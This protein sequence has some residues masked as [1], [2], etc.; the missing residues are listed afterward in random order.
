VV[1]NLEYGKAKVKA[2]AQ[3][4]GPE[5]NIAASTNFRVGSFSQKDIAATSDVAFTGGTSQ[6]VRA[7]SKEDMTKLRSALM[8][9][10]SVKAKDDLQ[11]KLGSDKFLI[12]KSLTTQI[13][14]EEYD[15][16]SDEPADSLKLNLG[17][18]AKAMVVNNSDFDQALEN[19]LLPLIPEGFELT[20]DIKKSIT[21]KKADSTGATI[22]IDVQA[23]LL[24]KLDENSLIKSLVGRPPQIARDNLSSIPGISQIDFIFTPSLPKFLTVLPHLPQNIHIEITAKK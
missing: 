9:D 21:I 2:Q 14:S 1:P 17:V 6:K 12:D 5:Y 10:L 18:S 16:K 24:P 11:K 23:S 19:K 20:K 8:E 22:Q 7:V 15:H 3:T 4:I 13:S